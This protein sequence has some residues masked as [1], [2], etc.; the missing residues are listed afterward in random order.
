MK[1]M[2]KLGKRGMVLLAILIV[3]AVSVSAVAFTYYMNTTSEHSV[4]RTWEITD[5]ILGDWTEPRE[6]GDDDIVFDTTDMVGGDEAKFLF[7]ISLS[8]NSNANK[9]LYFDMTNLFEAEGV[10]FVVYQ[11]GVGPVVD[12][13]FITFTP[14]STKQF[15]FN[16]TL[17]EY[18]PAGLYDVALKLEKQ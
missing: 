2:K 8:G 7:N 9:N 5:N 12:E 14:G 13:G 17:D 11:M 6:M 4:G 16:V 10:D 18:T 15:S 3:G 1:H